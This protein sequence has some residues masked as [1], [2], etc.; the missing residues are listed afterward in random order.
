M[1]IIAIYIEKFHNFP[2]LKGV[3]IDPYDEFWITDDK[4]ISPKSQEILSRETKPFTTL[5]VLFNTPGYTNDAPNVQQEI[6]RGIHP[7][8]YSKFSLKD[9]DNIPNVLSL[10]AKNVSCITLYSFCSLQF[11]QTIIRV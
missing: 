2:F 8:W 11:I 9:S 3:I 7:Y 10:V 4:L 6:K 1:I 5:N